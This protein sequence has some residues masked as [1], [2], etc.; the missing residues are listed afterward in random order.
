LRGSELA[1][2]CSKEYDLETPVLLKDEPLDSFFSFFN[3]ISW[4]LSPTLFLPISYGSGFFI[5]NDQS[6]ANNI[7]L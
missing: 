5:F 6:P 7:V 4:S 1:G 3:T 2:R